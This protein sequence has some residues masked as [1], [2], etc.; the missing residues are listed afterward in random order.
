[1]KRKSKKPDFRKKVLRIFSGKVGDRAPKLEGSYFPKDIQN[2]IARSLMAL[3]IKKE[4]AENIAFHL[5]DWN[6]DAAFIT[7]LILYPE[8]FTLDDISDGVVTLLVHA[9]NHLAAAAKLYGTPVTDVFQV[10]VTVK[11]EKP[12]KKLK[13]DAAKKRRAP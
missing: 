7:A 11:S 4:K 5:V 13:R 10:G 12:N 2:K 1:M 9:P 3:D 8:K 6:A